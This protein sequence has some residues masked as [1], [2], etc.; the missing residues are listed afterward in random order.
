MRLSE[1]IWEKKTFSKGF[2][3]IELM[4]VVAII[5][6]LATLTIPSTI[7]KRLQTQV[8]EAIYVAYNIRNDVS[9]YYAQHLT[10]PEDNDQAGV[11]EAD[12]L[13]GNLITSI[14]IEDGAIHI[15]LGNKAIKSLHGKVITLRPAVVIDSPESPISWLCGY[16]EPVTGMQAVGKNRTDI[17]KTTVPASCG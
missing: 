8:T 7:N 17:V 13:I 2:T 10:F 11:P 6:I 4:I 5:A 1:K 12:K 9:F 14:E 15:T 16:E 3:L